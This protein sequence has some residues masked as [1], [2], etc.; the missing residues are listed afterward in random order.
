M[1]TLALSAHSLELAACPARDRYYRILGRRKAVATPALTLGSAIHAA[2]QAHD[3][4]AP[5]PEQDALIR[6]VYAE[7]TPGSVPPDDYRQVGYALDAM[8]A[9][10]A[11]HPAPRWQRI[12]E[13]ERDF[14]TELGVVPGWGWNAATRQYEH[15]DV[16]V[17]WRGRRDRVVIAADARR[18]V[19][20][21]KTRSR[22]DATDWQLAQVGDQL[23][24]YV[25][26]WRQEYVDAPC[27]G[28]CLVR[29]IL[30]KPAK[31]SRATT[32]TF[33]FPKDAPILFTEAQVDEWHRQTLARAA[34]IAARNPN[35]PEA[36]WLERTMCGTRWGTCQYLATCSLQ[37]MQRGV[38]LGT[39]IY[40]PTGRNP[41]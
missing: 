26:Q 16:V 7:A 25:W 17:R 41:E 20:D 29:L 31:T 28:G 30:R 4:G 8:A 11:E 35:D 18:Y 33:E 6:A 13:S 9:Y 32:P 21:Y 3:A 5:A 39:D 19:V 24:G 34:A 12:E 2:L 15:G 36:W 27:A 22:D 14:D 40:A 38:H 23:L 10:R 1:L 37:P